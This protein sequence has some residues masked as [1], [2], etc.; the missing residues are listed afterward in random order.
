MFRISIP[1]RSNADNESDES[2]PLEAKSFEFVTITSQPSAINRKETSKTVRTQAM[3][4][5]LRKQNKEAITGVS[6][7]VSAVTLE[8]PARYKGRFKLN[9]WTH[10]AKK[11]ATNASNA[12]SRNVGDRAESQAV[13]VLGGETTGSAGLGSQGWKPISANHLP[14]SVFSVSS[15]LDPFDSLAV[16]LGPHSENLLVHCQLPHDCHYVHCIV[17]DPRH[18][19]LFS[20]SCVY[21]IGP[22]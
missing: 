1:D 8:E 21:L 9:T 12:K 6:E 10:K 13:V 5:Y 18:W 3:R 4:D 19:S 2:E 16:Q 15:R 7:V 22:G 17:L 11:K 14:N 20:F